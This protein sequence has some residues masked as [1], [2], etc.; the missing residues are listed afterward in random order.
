MGIGRRI[1]DIWRSRSHRERDGDA[2]RSSLDDTYRVQLA[3]LQKERRGVADV[4]TSRKRVE[5]RLRQLEQQAATFDAQ[6]DA[7]FPLFQTVHGRYARREV[8][9][10]DG[11]DD[12]AEPSPGAFVPDSAPG[13][14]HARDFIAKVGRCCGTLLQRELPDRRDEE[15]A[16]H[17]FEY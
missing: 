17:D 8:L 5:V 9:I 11:N 14:A 4:T 13:W 1:R 12:N 6:L 3:H 2:L 16:R 10:V 15:P 7:V